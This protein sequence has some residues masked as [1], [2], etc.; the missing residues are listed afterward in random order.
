MDVWLDG[1]TT[2]E[3]MT[4]IC[5]CDYREGLYAVAARSV[6]HAHRKAIAGPAAMVHELR[7]A[8]LIIILYHVYWY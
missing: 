1:R 3:A 2:F 5:D 8:T 7:V 6:S 4:T